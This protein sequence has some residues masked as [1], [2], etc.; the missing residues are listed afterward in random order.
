MVTIAAMVVIAV[1]VS[2]VIGTL[3]CS[4]RQARKAN[5]LVQ[6][7]K[8][9]N[10]KDLGLQYN[11]HY[12]TQTIVPTRLQPTIDTFPS[13]D[14]SK[15]HYV[16]E[17]GR[18]NFGI[19]FMGKVDKLK[20][21][22]GEALVAVKTLREENSGALESFVSEAKTMFSFDHPNIVKIHAV[23]MEEVPYYM[24]FEFMDKG[25]LAHFLQDSASSYQRQ[26]RSPFG[27]HERTE[28][29]L[30]NDPPQLNCEQLTDVCRQIASGMDYLSKKNHIHRDLACRN[31]L[32]SSPL[33]IKIGDFGMSQNLYT[34]DYYRVNGKA[35]LPIRWMSPEAVV[36]G[37]FTTQS[38]VWSFGV[39]M[40]EVFSFAM[41]PYYGV[42]NEEV[43]QMIRKGKHLDIPV[44]CPDKIYEI[45]TVCW[46]MDPGDRPSFSELH[47]ML[48]NFRS[49]TST[50]EDQ[51]GGRGLN[52]TVS[53]NSDVFSET[54]SCDGDIAA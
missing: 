16:K 43:T 23:C 37:K 40:W 4:K 53:L 45:M 9:E 25:D 13:L 7:Q 50:D 31:C 52:D 27:V 38:D 32:V 12:F 8:Q 10:K 46:S 28:S 29:S 42:T 51:H 6:L 26:K 35:V 21:G 18:G 2:G 39:V 14:R 24:V 17:L 5:L 1:V 54:A 48:V 20:E 33:N 34:R 30:S 36:Y 11:P 22:E 19:V 3:Y 41:Q 47:E 15:I 44:D 49:S